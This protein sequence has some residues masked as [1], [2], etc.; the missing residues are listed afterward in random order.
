MMP[1]P[2]VARDSETEGYLVRALRSPVSSEIIR[3][4]L[5]WMGSSAVVC[6]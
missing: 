6:V 3:Q 5:V 1:A 4:T 2:I